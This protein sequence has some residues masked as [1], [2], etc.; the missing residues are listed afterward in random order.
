MK[1]KGDD[2]NIGMDIYNVKFQFKMG[3]MVQYITKMLDKVGGTSG[4]KE[5]YG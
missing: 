3:S 4:T 1:W 5:A 2:S